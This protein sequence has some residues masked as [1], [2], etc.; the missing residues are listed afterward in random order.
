MV[1]ESIVE[2]FPIKNLE[3]AGSEIRLHRKSHS[4][5]TYFVKLGDL[6]SDINFT[7]IAAELKLFDDKL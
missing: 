6:P 5:V 2:K 1:P 7:P 3:S 4:A